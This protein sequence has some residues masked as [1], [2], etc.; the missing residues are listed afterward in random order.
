[1]RPLA[2]ALSEFFRLTRI[3]SNL[4]PGELAVRAGWLDAGAGGSVIARFEREGDPV[5]SDSEIT[6]LAEALNISADKVNSLES[7][8]RRKA[9]AEWEAWANE[10]VPVS[11]LLR[12]M[13]SIWHR[14]E[15][16]PEL[17]RPEAVLVWALA[18]PQHKA[19]MRC[20]CWSRRHATYIREDGTTYEVHAGF[21]DGGP[22]PSTAIT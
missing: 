7:E 18:A 20:I 21:G 11:L 14:V 16:P 9:R 12:G 4:S 13:P 1:M 6:R 10:R 22:G 2:G 5:L 19:Y 8:T 15:V 17:T 3:A